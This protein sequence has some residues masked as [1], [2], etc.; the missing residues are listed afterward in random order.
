VRVVRERKK[1]ATTIVVVC[2]SLSLSLSLI[3]LEIHTAN[4]FIIIFYNNKGAVYDDDDK[5]IIIIER[6]LIFS[7]HARTHSLLL[8][9]Y[10]HALFPSLPFH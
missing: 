9:F 4:H 10:I 6:E 2:L 5:Y 1:Y 3:P 8:V 7:I